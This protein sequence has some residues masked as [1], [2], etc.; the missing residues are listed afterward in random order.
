MKLGSAAARSFGVQGPLQAGAQARDGPLHA[1]CT[2]TLTHSYLSTSH[3]LLPALSTRTL[4]RPE[5]KH[6]MVRYLLPVRAQPP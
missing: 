5:H 4:H 1:I 6:E 3:M 2:T